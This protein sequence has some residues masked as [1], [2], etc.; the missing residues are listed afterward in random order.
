MKLENR[1]F[2]IHAEAH[3]LP[4]AEGFFDAI[5]SLDSYQYYGTDDLYLGYFH[6]F[7]KTGGQIGIVVPGL[8]RDFPVNGVPQHL[9]R[10]RENGKA[11]WAPEC[12][13]FHTA[14]WWEN[15]WKKSELVRVTESC[16]N[17]D[18]W[19]EWARYEHACEEAGTLLFPSEEETLLEDAGRNI[20][21]VRMVAE[22][23]S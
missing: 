6:K 16:I 4:Y 5:V 17:P 22:R 12:W 2:P 1:V 10:V 8:V 11:F 19:R 14:E 3:A 7:V 9:T 21:L 23:I 13:C 20:T 15:H 18:A